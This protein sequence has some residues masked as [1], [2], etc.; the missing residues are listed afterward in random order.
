LS[1]YKISFK[2][3]TYEILATNNLHIV[4]KDGAAL[5]K[6]KKIGLIAALAAF[7]VASSVIYKQSLK[8][9][10]NNKWTLIWEDDFKN[11]NG[12]AVDASK[13]VYDVG[14]HGWGNN[15]HQY[16]TS[17]TN[18]CYIQDS[19][20]VIEAKK[21]DFEGKAYTSARIKTK[22]KFEFQYGKVEMRAKLPYG[23]GIWPAFWMLGEDINQVDW[24]NCGEIDIMEFIG[25]DP[26]KVYATA[27]GPGYSGDKSIGSSLSLMSAPGNDYH[28]YSI[29]WSENKIEWFI[30]GQKYHTV[31]T[32]NVGSNPWA[33]NR[34]FFLMLNLAV[35]GNWPGYPDDTT[36][37]PQKYLIDY[38]RVYQ[39]K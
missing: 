1:S 9:E 21:E 11:V 24:P 32:E 4:R 8:N 2:L 37:F 6:G 34:K 26:Q 33:F 17:G 31:T 13:W 35:G 12:S 15:E 19:N 30:D 23:Q 27:H 14:G 25:K 28:I 5:L 16:Y 3:F 38:V 7:A 20:L 39:L 10:Q 22:G 18:N 36:V 29:E